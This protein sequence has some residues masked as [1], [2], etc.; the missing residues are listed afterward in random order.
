MRWRYRTPDNLLAGVL[1]AAV[2]RLLGHS[3]ASLTLRTYVSVVPS[4][5]S[6]G[7]LLSAAVGLA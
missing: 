3:D 2:A 6:D 7:D 1:I 5:L 4:G